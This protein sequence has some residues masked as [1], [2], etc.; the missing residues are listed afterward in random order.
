MRFSLLLTS[1]FL[2]S[3]SASAHQLKGDRAP[4]PPAEVLDVYDIAIEPSAER[5]KNDIQTLVDF[6]TRH[7]LSETKSETRGIGAARRRQR[8]RHTARNARP[9][10]ICHDERRY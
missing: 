9:E 6:G 7:T 2:L 10:P 4:V 3:V 1:A 5:I 8:H